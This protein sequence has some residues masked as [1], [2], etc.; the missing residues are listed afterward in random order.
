MWQHLVCGGGCLT[1]VCGQPLAW[2]YKQAHHANWLA[3]CQRPSTYSCWSCPIT[4]AVHLFCVQAR[5]QLP[6]YV[7]QLASQGA[8][9]FGCEA[10]PH[11]W[12][13]QLPVRL[14][15]MTQE[16]QQLPCMASSILKEVEAAASPISP[17]VKLRRAAESLQCSLCFMV[18]S[19]ICIS[20][21]RMRSQ[22]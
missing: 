16:P 21:T 13:M 1:N 20:A 11:S 14:T 18:A 7:E 3:A 9:A 12:I 17:L 10:F 22:I 8:S 6:L 4:R 5:S 15:A 2:L 19:S